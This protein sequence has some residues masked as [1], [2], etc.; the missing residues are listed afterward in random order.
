[1]GKIDFSE[2]TPYAKVFT[3]LTKER[4]ALL[5]EAG[6]VIKPALADVTERFY[7]VLQ[8]IDTTAP[9]LEG[10]LADLKKTHQAWLESL[11][12]GP[13]DETYAQT[14]Y[15]VGQVHVK[16]D[17]P[18]EF[19][20]GGMSLIV[21]ELIALVFDIY[22]DDPQH[23]PPLLKAINAITGFSLLIMQQSYQSSSLSA[24]LDRFLAITGMSRTLFEN[25]AGAYSN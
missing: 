11:F 6:P 22:G 12:T 3:G 24:E 20:S 7:T 1:M 21:D 13:F 17:L 23:C 18:V 14:M 8:S 16:V 19:M 10:R 2:L 9:F 4:E 25:L 15:H 5:I